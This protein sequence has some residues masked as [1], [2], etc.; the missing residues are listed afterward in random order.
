MN[1]WPSGENMGIPSIFNSQKYFVEKGHTV[2]FIC[3]AN[4]KEQGYENYY[5]INIYRFKFPLN[6]H[7]LPSL[8]SRLTLHKFLTRLI[9][10]FI[11][12][13]DWLMFEICSLVWAIKIAYRFKPDIIYAHGLSPVF[14]AWIVSKIFRTKFIIRVYGTRELYWAYKNTLSRM[15]EFRDYWALKIPASY[16]IITK[17]ATRADLLAK[18]LG[19]PD[20]K[21]KSYRNGVE[22]DMY[23]PDP[24]IKKRIC[25]QLG[26][27]PKLKIIISTARIIPFYDVGK[28][29]YALPQLFKENSE[30]VCIIAGDGPEKKS[31]E[32]FVQK[33][34]IQSRVFWTGKV[35]RTYIKDLL[36]TADIYVSTSDYSNCNNNTWEAMVT[37]KC[38][39]TIEDELTK[40]IIVSG[41]DGIL[42]QKDKLHT[43]PQVLKELLENA[44]YRQQLA[45]AMLIKSK[46]V[47]E[48]W[49]QRMEKELKLLEELVKNGSRKL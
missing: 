41:K 11:F 12:N 25:E 18:T 48:T 23:N 49:P 4:A 32:E 45:N 9:S 19:V 2:H 42:I 5:G 10:S 16:L 31:L 1:I 8:L 35:D 13:L 7:I 34:N 14:P 37:G 28:L 29:V 40:E 15:K 30:S 17:D 44:S 21:I 47:L 38:I 46:E 22:F 39:V 36:N 26:I 20:Y 3:P 43:L 6:F 33:H 27:N 24:E